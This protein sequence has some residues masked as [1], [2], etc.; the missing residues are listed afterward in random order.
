MLLVAHAS[1][2]RGPGYP[3]SRSRRTATLAR[4][5]QHLSDG[6]PWSRR[7]LDERSDPE[8]RTPRGRGADLPPQSTWYQPGMVLVPTGVAI[9]L[10]EAMAGSHPRS[11]WRA[12]LTIVNAPGTVDAGYRGQIMVCLLNTDRHTPIVLRR[13]D[14]I[15]QPGAAG[16]AR[17]FSRSRAM[18]SARGDGGHGSTGASRPGLATPGPAAGARLDP[19]EEGTSRDLWPIQREERDADQRDDELPSRTWRPNPPTRTPR[20]S[21]TTATSGSGWTPAATGART[22]RSTSARST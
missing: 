6:G 11:S 14:L 1:N 5:S 3:V 8:L 4:M 19:I 22:A 13:G 18:A 10:P 16:R 15:A 2:P 17:Q 21:R 9:A 7:L 20:T 12:Q